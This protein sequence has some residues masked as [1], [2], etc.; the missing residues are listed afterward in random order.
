MHVT[1]EHNPRAPLPMCGL[2]LVF[3]LRVGLSLLLI[4]LSFNFVDALCIATVLGFLCDFCTNTTRKVGIRGYNKVVALAE[5]SHDQLGWTQDCKPLHHRTS[6]SLSGLS[7]NSDI[8]SSSESQRPPPLDNSN[9]Q[10]QPAKTPKSKG[11]P[12]GLVSP[13]PI[14]DVSSSMTTTLRVEESAGQVA[15]MAG[16]GAVESSKPNMLDHPVLKEENR[17]ANPQLVPLQPTQATKESG[18]LLSRD[19][20]FT[21]MWASKKQLL[22]QDPLLS[23]P[24]ST[25]APPRPHTSLASTPLVPRESESGTLSSHIRSAC[26]GFG[27]AY[28]GGSKEMSSTCVPSTDSKADPP[29]ITSTSMHWGIALIAMV[30]IVLKVIN[31]QKKEQ[32]WFELRQ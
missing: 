22:V 11:T 20:K 8:I 10:R 6:Q 13:T 14:F 4:P 5:D 24:Q 23:R 1:I 15:T 28:D 17:T 27:K 18:H 2:L 25:S 21:P 7:K 9:G 16:P 19:P 29:P 31:D 26:S 32:P 12:S 30:E 3:L